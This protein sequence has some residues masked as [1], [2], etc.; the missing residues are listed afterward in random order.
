MPFNAN[1]TAGPEWSQ[2]RTMP[3]WRAPL[4]RQLGEIHGHSPGPVVGQPL[5]D[6]APAQVIVV[7]K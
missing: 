1:V 4:C 6:G 7:V 2:K 3:E 5:S